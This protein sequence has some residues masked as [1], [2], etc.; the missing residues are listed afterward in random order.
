M[1]HEGV[2]T[3]ARVQCVSSCAHPHQGPRDCCPRCSGTGSPGWGGWQGGSAWPAS[4][5]LGTGWG[6]KDKPFQK[7]LPFLYTPKSWGLGSLGDRERHSWHCC[8]PEGSLVPFCSYPTPK[9]VSTRAGSM[10]QGTASSLGQTPVKCASVRWV[11]AVLRGGAPWAQPGH[12]GQQALRG[13]ETG[14]EAGL[15]AKSQQGPEVCG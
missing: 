3:C 10:S 2:V 14:G 11:R 6:G 5:C 1:C 7:W 4:P 13:S 9:A 12:C 8:Q 15:G